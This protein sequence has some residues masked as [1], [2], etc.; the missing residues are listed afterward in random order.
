MKFFFLALSLLSVNVY[1]QASSLASTCA[2]DSLRTSREESRVFREGNTLGFGVF[3]ECRFAF[4]QEI[5]RATIKLMRDCQNAGYQDCTVIDEGRSCSLAVTGY[6]QVALSRTQIRGQACAQAAL[7]YDQAI[8]SS[9]EL[10]LNFIEVA[11]R[12]RDGYRCR[13]F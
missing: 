8:I 7:C 13:N 6:R 10:S 9:H 3:S 4:Q 11:T 12:V 1:A 5:D 2:L